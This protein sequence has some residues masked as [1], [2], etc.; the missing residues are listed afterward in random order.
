MAK[1]LD[2]Y[3]GIGAVIAGAVLFIQGIPQITLDTI[4]VI[5]GVLVQLLQFNI[6]DYVVV[7]IA[8]GALAIFAGFNLLK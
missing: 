3:A 6:S 7:P 2:L 1:N 5:G 4:P 8:A